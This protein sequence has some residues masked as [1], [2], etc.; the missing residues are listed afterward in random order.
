MLIAFDSDVMTKE[1][2]RGALKRLTG[3]LR[4]RGATVR[5]VIL[6]SDGE[7]VGLDDYLAAGGTSPT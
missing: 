5:L 3:W 6:A 1:S 7:K 4:F 2:V